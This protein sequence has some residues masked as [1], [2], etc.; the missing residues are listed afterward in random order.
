MKACSGFEYAGSELA[1]FAKAENWKR[2]WSSQ[3]G[4]YIRGNVLEVGAGIGANTGLFANLNWRTWTSLE[5]DAK[6]ASQI[7]AVSDQHSAVVGTL[8]DLQERFDTVLYI[9]VLEHVEDDCTELKLAATHLTS[10]ANLIV[11]A[12]AH[13]FL[14]TP[15]DATIGHYRRYTRRSLGAAAPHEL[16]PITTFYLD[17]AGMLASAANRVLLKAAMPT[18]R[19]IST[20]D[21]L[22]VPI[23]RVVDPLFG[24]RLGKSVVGIWR[25]D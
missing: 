23:S 15:F 22:L 2:Y 24:W 4:P 14:Y 21:R 5:P 7:R 12:P 20:W 9:D 6:L 25:H 19:Q 16:R 18:A 17:A 1:L 11:L 13:S 8:A 3:I 10:G